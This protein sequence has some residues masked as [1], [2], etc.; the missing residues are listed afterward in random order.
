MEW[1]ELC[2]QLAR[3]ASS[4]LG[5]RLC[6]SLLP[7][8][9]PHEALEAQQRTNEMVRILEGSSWF[10]MESFPDLNPLIERT[11]RGERLNGEELREIGKVLSLVKRVRRYLEERAD[12]S[13]SLWDLAS[14]LQEEAELREAVESAV[15]PEGGLKDDASPR[16]K[17]LRREVRAR[18]EAIERRL[19]SF[20]RGKE[21]SRVLQ[22]VYYTIREGRYVLPVRSDAPSALQGI[23]HDLS[24]SGATRFME[25]TWLV[26]LN[27]AFRLAQLELKK[28][29]E[30]VLEELSR[31]VARSA[32][33][34]MLN[35]EILARLDL[36]LAMARL[37]LLLKATPP[38]PSCHGELVLRGMRHPLLILRKGDAVPND[39]ILSSGHRILVVSGPNAGGKTVLLKTV[40]LCILMAMAGMHIPCEEGSE[41]PF[42]HLVFSDM[43]DQ[44]DLQQDISTFSGHMRNIREILTAVGDGA[45][46]LLDE[47]AGST[48][49]QEGA[50]LAMAVLERLLRTGCRVLV[51][52]HYPTLKSW[53]Q[54]REGVLNGGMEFDWDRMEPTY[55]LH[56]GVPGRSSALQVA[57]RMG[58]PDDLIEEARS[59]LE[60]RE[61]DVEH[62]LADLERQRKTLKEE[63]DRVRA[64]RE[65]LEKDVSR[66]EELIRTLRKEKEEFVR[67]K[68][69]RLA[70]EI[71]ETRR[72]IREIHKALSGARSLRQV[73]EARNQ[74][75]QVESELVPPPPESPYPLRPLEEL[76]PGEPVV[77]LSL[78]RRGILLDDPRTSK[79]R[80]RV[81]VGQVEMWVARE[82]LG[83][84]EPRQGDVEEGPPSGATLEEIRVPPPQEVPGEIDLRGM[85]VEEALEAVARYL[86]R[87]LLGKREEVRL[88]HGHGT[89]ALKG[90]VRKWL[91]E[92]PWIE[93]FRPGDRHEGG[94]GATVVRLKGSTSMEGP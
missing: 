38:Q 32:P 55:R 42:S 43:G 31:R 61:T 16:L 2:G 9:S 68:R 71:Q 76:A 58:L 25:P 28:E 84:A 47:L 59:Y 73:D 91:E 90:A 57:A 36:V 15:D 80:L 41:L 6:I 70:S 92:C 46:I 7:S 44:Q 85:R 81:K 78:G 26:D 63:T 14:V 77:I 62:L 35:L 53:A 45:I 49:P 82:A 50:A 10:P 56:I 19:E 23:V 52:T 29:E 79:R 54:R 17:H 74:L 48:D 83:G 89:G 27:N 94:D 88:V 12:H 87:A 39:V 22:D 4:P 34:L 67:E 13:Y 51:T 37:S 75:K 33:N 3:L 24:A 64:L 18:R 60:G 65:R 5:R 20:L 66:Q 11:Q 1:P 8:E 21:A 30:R 69:R 93:G 72:R 86:D 40:G